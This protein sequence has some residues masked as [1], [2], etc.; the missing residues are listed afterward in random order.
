MEEPANGIHPA[1]LDAMVELLRDLAVD[2]DEP[3]GDDNPF[4]QIIVNTHS[5]SFVQ[6]LNPEELLFATSDVFRD[7]AGLV[8]R[9]LRLAPLKGTWRDGRS[10]EPPVSKTD[11]LPYLTTPP[12]SQ[13][14]LQAIPA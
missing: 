6:L 14:T 11:I 10:Q 5:P 7:S 8:S 4:R 9:A 2:P 12:G 13:L 3:P 1:N